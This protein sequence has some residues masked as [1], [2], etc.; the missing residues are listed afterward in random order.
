[1]QRSVTEITSWERLMASILPCYN[2]KGD[3]G[4]SDEG[5]K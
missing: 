5:R 4:G 1:L 3:E 2:F